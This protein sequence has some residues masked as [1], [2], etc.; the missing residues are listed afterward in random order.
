MGNNSSKATAQDRAILDMKIQRDQLRKYQKQITVIL[1]REQEIAKECLRKGDKRRALLALRKK[2]YQ[3]QLLIKTDGQLETLEQLTRS[4][5]FALVQKDVL[6]GLQQGNQV[7]KTLNQE[8]SIEKVEKIMDESAEGIAY[9]QEVTD[10]LSQTIT[11][12]DE[13]EVQE[14]LDRLEQEELAKKM[15]AMPEVSTD[16]PVPELP[17]VPDTKLKNPQSEDSH[18]QPVLA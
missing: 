16:Q 1:N 6:Y 11:N 10:M 3:E 15:P 9:Q 17:N 2:K 4:I 12:Q 14:E 18:K 13:A 8:M 5:E 7:L